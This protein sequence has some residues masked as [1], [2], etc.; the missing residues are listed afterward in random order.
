MFEKER[1]LVE[2]GPHSYN[3]KEGGE[4]GWDYINENDIRKF[5]GKSHSLESKQKISTNTTRNYHS[6]SIETRKKISEKVKLAHF[7]KRVHRSPHSDKR[8]KIISDSIKEKWKD[9][10]YSNTMKLSFKKRPK[11]KLT[12]EQRKKLSE[13]M[14]RWHS[15]RA[16]SSASTQ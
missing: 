12:D 6:H 2:V 11:R 5:K 7:E 9:E 3:L 16:E 10:E 15:S 1:E 4:G 8:K 14:K 13:S